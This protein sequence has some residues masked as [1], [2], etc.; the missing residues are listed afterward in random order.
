MIMTVKVRDKIGS[1]EIEDNGYTKEE[2]RGIAEEF[3][4]A[5]LSDFCGYEGKEVNEEWKY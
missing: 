5:I 2:I 4:L 3:V 1:M